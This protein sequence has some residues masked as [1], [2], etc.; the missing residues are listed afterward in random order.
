MNR[1]IRDGVLAD[2]RAGRRVIVFS[3]GH[4]AARELLA[5]F[6]EHVRDGER[7]Y[8]THG[9]ERVEARNSGGWVRFMSIAAGVRGLSADV[10]VLDTQ[11]SPQ[12]L[13]EI[14]P[15]TSVGGEV[16]SR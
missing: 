8:R 5:S 12:Q 6:A 15:I 1:Y 16:M 3:R 11:P 14:V 4:L 10:V 2:M 7:V 13:E 9:S